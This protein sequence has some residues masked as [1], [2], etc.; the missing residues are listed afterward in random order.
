MVSQN[1]PV[2]CVSV[3]S[4]NDTTTENEKRR[5]QHKPVELRLPTVQQQPTSVLLVVNKNQ[6][7]SFGSFHGGLWRCAYEVDSIGEAS[8]FIYFGRLAKPYLYAAA[9][10]GVAAVGVLVATSS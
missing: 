8:V 1:G 9:A 2:S 5:H 6:L 4:S 7:F 3:S 10:V